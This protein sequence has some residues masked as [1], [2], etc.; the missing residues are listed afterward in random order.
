MANSVIGALRVMLGMD[1]AE[2]EKGATRAQRETARFEKNL[3]K[4]G[5][6]I[7]RIG[8]NL[9]ASLTAPIM[10]AAAAFSASAHIIARESREIA[11]SAQVAGESFEEFQRQAHAAKT[12][13][14]EFDKLGDIFKDVKDRVGDF[15]ATGGGPMADFFENIA[16]K[17]G[18]TADAFRDLSGKDALQL[19]FDSLRKANVSS[20]EMVFY[21]EAMASD[22]T[23]LIPL[24]EKSGRGFEE[25]GKRANIISP[26]QQAD[27]ERYLVA[28]E[29]LGEATQKLVIAFVE[30]GMLDTVVELVESFAAWTSDLAE[31][32]PELLKMGT[33]AAA[34]LAV[35][36]PIITA[37]GALIPLLRLLP[38]LL[39]GVGFAFRFAL[40]PIGWAML[41]IEGVYLAWKNWDKIEPILRRLYEGAKKW[42]KDNLG[43]VLTWVLNP[44][45]A[46]KDAFFHLY[47]AVVGNSYVPDMVDGIQ[48]EMARLQEVMVDPAASAAR[49]VEDEM[50]EMASEVSALLD[51]LFPEI[52]AAQQMLR[53]RALI[54][55]SGLSD[56][57]KAEARLRLVGG[58]EARDVSFDTGP[59]AEAEK[60]SQAAE[61][62]TDAMTEQAEKAKVQ[63]VRIAETF[64][65]MAKNV[66]S[67]LRGL[68]DDIR[69]G[70]FFDVL[71]GI[72]DMVISLG[73]TGLF[74]KGFATRLNNTDF[75]GF[76]AMGGPVEAGRSYIVGERGAE[77]F[78]PR[79]GGQIVSNDNLRA[80]GGRVDVTVTM[81]PSTGQLGAFVRN[82]SGRMI[83]RAAPAIGAAS[84]EAT[85]GKL[86]QMQGRRLD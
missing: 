30:S 24:L 3:E 78:T 44:I 2:F 1:T 64:A 11:T 39:R 53:D 5:R 70:D 60:V 71:G 32:N 58:R 37:I 40:G 29:R 75:G 13:G 15:V 80:M 42:I 57:A 16:P 27:F 74:G 23:A 25:I 9:T 10:G 69:N 51:R 48:R 81:D 85:I 79:T 19:Y 54:E 52:A 14:I 26:K 65:D 50:R 63:T 31:T 35:L 46:V 77:L 12:V 38:A 83:A 34:I 86:R 66:M 41:A 8:K 84:R 33:A 55:G 49:S 72:L 4:A 62:I 6:K 18:V 20:D 28:Q 56:S 59:L 68:V 36:G 61:K 73:K 82:E 21:L 67:S 7:G 45:S 76:R 17:V 47:D 22:A 43:R